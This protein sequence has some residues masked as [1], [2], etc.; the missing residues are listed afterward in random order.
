MGDTL[1]LDN[2]HCLRILH[3]SK[4]RVLNKSLIL[5]HGELYGSSPTVLQYLILQSLAKMS[6]LEFCKVSTYYF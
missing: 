2:D 1:I 5:L 3:Y 6:P 4:P